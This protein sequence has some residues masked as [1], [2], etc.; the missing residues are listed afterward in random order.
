MERLV[1]AVFGLAPLIVVVGAVAVPFAL[2]GRAEADQPLLARTWL[3]TLTVGGMCVDFA[4]W[5]ES[6]LLLALLPPIAIAP[7]IMVRRRSLLAFGVRGAGAPVIVAATVV[8]TSVVLLSRT[9]S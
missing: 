1:A 2:I 7:A 8:L 6:W 5:T 9:G 4:V 3:G